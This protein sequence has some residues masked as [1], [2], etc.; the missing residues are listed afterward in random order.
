MLEG[1]V[2]EDSVHKIL[3]NVRI[4]EMNEAETLHRHEQKRLLELLR[5]SQ[6]CNKKLELKVEKLLDD[7]GDIL[8]QDREDL[9]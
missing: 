6:S 5:A 8:L 9:I 1:V 4:R 3:R 2:A 7:A